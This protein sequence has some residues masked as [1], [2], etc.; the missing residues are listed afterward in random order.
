MATPFESLRGR[1]AFPP[2]PL[3]QLY[4][5]LRGGSLPFSAPVLC[6]AGVILP[7]PA[8]PPEVA[9]AVLAPSPFWSSDICF[10]ASAESS[11]CA[12]GA[13]SPIPALE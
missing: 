2:A 11:P 9:F 5:G 3:R 10:L 1:E 6:E 4:S 7:A 13:A 8:A 12:G